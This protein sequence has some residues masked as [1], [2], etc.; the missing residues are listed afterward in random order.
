MRT[1]GA[2]LVILG[3]AACNPVALDSPRPDLQR[4]SPAFE[5]LRSQF[6]REILA[7]EGNYSDGAEL[8]RAAAPIAARIYGAH[9]DLVRAETLRTLLAMPEIDLSRYVGQPPSE[10]SFDRSHIMA[11][12]SEMLNPGGLAAMRFYDANA[13]AFQAASMSVRPFDD[14]DSSSMVAI[15]MALVGPRAYRGR[16]GGSDVLAARYFRRL[17]VV[18]YSITAEGMIMPDFAQLSVYPLLP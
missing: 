12:M 8:G 9:W 17:V 6:E 3:L 11:E 13:V 1:L 14:G 2:L 10:P 18:P 4:P 15:K 16:M 7:V 5:Q